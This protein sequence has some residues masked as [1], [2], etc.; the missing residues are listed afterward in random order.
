MRPKEKE[1]FPTDH[2]SAAFGKALRLA[3]G[4]DLTPQRVPTKRKAHPVSLGRLGGNNGGMSRATSFPPERHPV[5]GRMGPEKRWGQQKLEKSSRLI[6]A[7]T[8]SAILHRIASL[9][10]L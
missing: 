2:T 10:D 9:A 8:D 7:G 3:R 1:I 6:N 4:P 5:V